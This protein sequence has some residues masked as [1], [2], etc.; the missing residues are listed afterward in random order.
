MKRYPDC[1]R[2]D[3]LC[4][5]CSLVNRGLDCHNNKINPLLYQRSLSKMTQGE[6]ANASG[7]N[8]RQIQ[9]YEKSASDTGNMTLRNAVA[10]SSALDC[11]PED[12]L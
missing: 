8:I 11:A 4:G 9:R 12:L 1:I 2:T 7:V 5:I 6:L 10:I 3:G